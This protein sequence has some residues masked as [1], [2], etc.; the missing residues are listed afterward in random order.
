VTAEPK[1][2]AAHLPV[3]LQ[4]QL[5]NLMNVLHFQDEALLVV[6]RHLAH[7]YSVHLRAAPLP[8]MDENVSATWLKESVFPPDLNSY[9]L[10]KIIVPGT[11]RI[12]E[13]FPVADHFDDAGLNFSLPEEAYEL[14]GRVAIRHLCRLQGIQI[15]LLQHS[16][17]FSGQLLDFSPQALRVRL[18]T[19]GPQN[20][21]WLN[22]ALPATLIISKDDKPIYSGLVKICSRDEESIDGKVYILEPLESSTPRF[23]PKKNRSRR[24]QFRPS[25][26]LVFTHPLSGRKCTL[27]IESLGSLGFSVLEQERSSVLLSG[28][29]LPDAQ[30]SF[31][32]S[33]C[34]NCTVQVVF[35]GQPID[36]VV[37]SGV[38]LLD[39]GI[40]DHLKLISLIQQAQD[41]HAYVSNQVD[42]E[43][44]F[45]FFF[46]TGFL[47]PHKYA[48]MAGNRE[49]FKNAYMKLY[50][51]GQDLS[52]HF[53]YQ[54]NGQILGHFAT[55]RTHRSTWMNH[56]HAALPNHR[57]GLKVVRAI[58]EFVN[59]S[60]FLNPTNLKYIIGFYRP[61]NRFPDRYFGGFVR[62]AN[63][64]KVT[65]LDEFAYI[66]QADQIGD[67]WHDKPGE[68]EIA[69]A[70]DNDIAAFRNYYQQQSGG[71]MA[72]AFDLD[73][74][75]YDDTTLTD[76]YHTAGLKRC[77]YFYAVRHHQSLK[78]LVEV[79]DSALGLNMS[80][81]TNAIFVYVVD[82]EALDKKL[83]QMV[84]FALATKHNKQH[85]PVM[86][87]P[88]Q[89]AVRHDFKIDKSYN[90]WTLN[91]RHTQDYMDWLYRY[92]RK[93]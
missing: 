81:L 80:E 62:N 15:S 55:I 20:F 51:G 18:Q 53:I 74:G 59:D 34:L 30:L 93:A 89:Y 33:L 11:H 22:S 91:L 87:Y 32:N 29:L 2:A 42:P 63:N 23:Q 57:A 52:R 61:E 48:E 43:A 41:P 84:V 36:G 39:I 47:Y 64:N 68:W 1:I 82:Q 71:L 70:N 5:I 73:V 44:L 58:S 79:Q 17:C 54:D 28:L 65:S 25:P 40:K 77:R 76:A 90:L 83:F 72:Q 46:E 6:L 75:A 4:H 31:A 69:R 26:D 10:E 12:I 14:S 49:G 27:K 35:R 16:V 50:E 9:T 66:K 92:F 8:S 86:I 88:R 45:E 3:I 56:H 21:F 67:D 78:A 60:Y 19:F 13:I 7:G 38:A 37:K 24:E 85:H